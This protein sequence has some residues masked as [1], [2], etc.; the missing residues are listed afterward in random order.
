MIKCEVAVERALVLHPVIGR[1]M[2]QRA[3]FELE[4]VLGL[5][6][7]LGAE[8]CAHQIIPLKTFKSGHYFGSGKVAEL[9]EL[10]E[11]KQVSIVI[12]NASVTPI[13]QRNLERFWKVKVIDRTGV[14][15]EIFGLRAVT[16]EGRLQVELARLNYERS[17]LVR[18]WTHLERQAGGQGF[19]QV[20]VSR[21][22]NLT[23]DILPLKSRI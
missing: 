19:S 11:R 10:I 17:R 15:L 5:T 7:A 1:P 8:L 21:R 13:Q 3:R 16:K 18:T 9:A 12:V 22:L 23:E 2:D 20:L 14:I 6:E 4:E